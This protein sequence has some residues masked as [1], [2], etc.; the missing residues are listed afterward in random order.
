MFEKLDVF[1]FTLGLTE[2]WRNRNDGAVFPLP[3]G[4]SGGEMNDQRYEFINF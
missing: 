4:V 1:T 2:A 3:P